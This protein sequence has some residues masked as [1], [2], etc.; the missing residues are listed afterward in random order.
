MEYNRRFPDPERRQVQLR[1]LL[2]EVSPYV[3][4]FAILDRY[5]D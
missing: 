4:T 1:R 3:P 2:S 5:A